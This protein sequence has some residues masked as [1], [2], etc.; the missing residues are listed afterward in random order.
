MTWRETYRQPS[1]RGVAFDDVPT[2]GLT[3]GRRYATHVYPGRDTHLQEDLGRTPDEFSIDAL[4]IGDDFAQRRDALLEELEKPGAGRLIHPWFGEISVVAL[5]WNVRHSQREGRACRFRITFKDAGANIRPV[6]E[7]D[8]ALAIENTAVAAETA[9][10]DDFITWFNPG[11]PDDFVEDAAVVT[12]DSQLTSFV[13]EVA[14]YVETGT[15][16]IDTALGIA[17]N[18]RNLIRNPLGLISAVFPLFG[19]LVGL[20]GF[21]ESSILRAL[22]FFADSND[23]FTP[24]PLTTARR[25]Q[26]A[27]NQTALINLAKRTAAITEARLVPRI[28]FETRDD[29]IATRDSVIANLDELILDA[30]PSFNAAPLRQLQ[31]DVVAD[32]NPRA[33]DLSKISLYRPALTEPLDVIAHR[34]YGDTSQ[35]NFIAGRNRIR[36]PEFVVGGQAI[37]VRANG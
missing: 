8:S 10:S 4:I 33:L 24:V 9:I 21:A 6:A 2:D 25:R 27:A 17:T 28:V 16:V 20:A 31:A 19:R 34:L 14:F 37:E 11:T 26:Q 32:V 18:V 29:A 13:D 7:I 5:N 35:A 23:G 15:A 12:L 22:R 30:A 3:G 1:F 36:H